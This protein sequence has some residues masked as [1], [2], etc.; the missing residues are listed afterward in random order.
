MPRGDSREAIEEYAH[1]ICESLRCVTHSVIGFGQGVTPVGRVGT[2]NFLPE[3]TAPLYG[4]KKLALFFSHT[5]ESVQDSRDQLWKVNTR[6]YFYSVYDC[7][8]GERHEIFSYQWH[9]DQTIKIPHVHFKKGEPRITRAHLPTGRVSIESIV[10]LLI[11]D[12]G[13]KGKAKWE[14]IIARNRKLPERYEY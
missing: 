11:Q 8:N 2:L 1:S 12:L 9:P 7:H 4:T 10:E 5:Y 3:P 14:S 6:S 13:V